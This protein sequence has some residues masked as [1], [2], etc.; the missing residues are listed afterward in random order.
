MKPNNFLRVKF[1]PYLMLLFACAIVQNMQAQI[2]GG[3]PSSIK[4][5]QINTPQARIIFPDYIDSIGNRAANVIQSQR[6]LDSF[7]IG[8]TLRK[9][10]VVLQPEVTYYNGYVGLG[11]FRSEFFLQPSV[12]VFGL[13]ALPPED[14]L[15]I[16]EYR[17]VQ[18]YANFH[19]GLSKYASWIFGE[20]GQALFNAMAV[21]NWFF[22]GDAVYNETRL[23]EQGRGRMPLFMNDFRALQ[24]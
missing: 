20:N 13:G 2:F 21:P 22:E 10:N 16:H 1:F 9:I 17:H 19:V 4:W 12:N 8:N 7:S 23:S 11:P 6:N 14:N 5:K 3:N 24:L 15:G 18:Q